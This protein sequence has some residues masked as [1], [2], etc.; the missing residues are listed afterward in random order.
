MLGTWVGDVGNGRDVD[1]GEDEDGVGGDVAVMGT[2][3]L[4]RGTWWW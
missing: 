3:V 4:V 2:R 1:G